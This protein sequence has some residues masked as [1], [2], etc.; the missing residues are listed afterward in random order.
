MD[1]NFSEKLTSNKLPK[2]AK[3]GQKVNGL[4]LNGISPCMYISFICHLFI[5]K[6]VDYVIVNLSSIL[7]TSSSIKI[8]GRRDGPDSVRLRCMI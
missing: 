1:L 7:I 4:A 2:M 8:T 5:R 3:F 6:K